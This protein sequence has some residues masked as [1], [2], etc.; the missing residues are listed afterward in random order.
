M[1]SEL[2]V[3]IR[4]TNAALLGKKGRPGTEAQNGAQP[5]KRQRNFAVA[6]VAAFT[7]RG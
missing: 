1:T 2:F 6:L 5:T 3:Q 7:R 4:A